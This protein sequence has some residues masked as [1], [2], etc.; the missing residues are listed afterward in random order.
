[1]VTQARLR[2]RTEN[3]LVAGVA[4]GVADRL[5]ASVGFVRVFLVI[6]AMA[7]LPFVLGLYTLAALLIPPRG[8]NRP[9]WD[10]V[11]CLGRTGLVVV[12]PILG[13]WPG[14]VI[15]EPL[16]GPLGWWIAQYG[17]LVAGA[18]ALLGADYRRDRT[19][20]RAE[21]R[22]IVLAA[23]PVA[24]SLLA[25]GALMLV[26]PDVRWER[27]VPLAAIVGAAALLLAG[28]R[29]FRTGFL[30][31]AML[32]AAA[33]GVV[34]GSGAR[35]EGGVGDRSVA[36]RAGAGEPVV[37]RRAIGDVRLDLRRITR[38]GRDA[39]VD[40]SVGLGTIHVV[41]PSRVRL[42]LDTS[43]GRGRIAPYIGLGLDELQGFDQH[44]VSNVRPRRAEGAL[45][46][47]RLRARVG[48]GEIQVDVREASFVEEAV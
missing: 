43:V 11:I 5:N 23:L 30:A 33:A 46:T 24:I 48:V 7:S 38:G 20:T 47:I 32:A 44:L 31:P 4:G 12:V 39:S 42:E 25:L 9:D 26:A 8:S 16:N 34:V 19:R 3:R 2:R 29:G 40:A 17:V 18:A 37:V 22:G 13:L 35:L 21:A 27:F 1:V 28:S 45:P 6:G 10:N 36:P 41:V 14:T 15:N